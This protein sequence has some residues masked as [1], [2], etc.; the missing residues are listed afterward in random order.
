MD[1]RFTSTEAFFRDASGR[2]S[3]MPD[4]LVGVAPEV[5]RA[6]VCSVLQLGAM[7]PPWSPWVGVERLVPRGLVATPCGLEQDAVADVESAANELVSRIDAVLREIEKPVLLFSGG[8]DSGLLAARLAALGRDDA[9]LFHYSFGASGGETRVAEAMAR[10]F[11]LKLEI[12]GA[13]GMDPLACLEVPGRIYPMPFADESTA[14]MFGLASVVTERFGG[15]G[16]TVIDGTGAD[17]A[18]GMGAKVRQWMKILKIPKGVRKVLGLPYGAGAWL[19]RGGVEYWP[20]LMERS[21]SPSPLAAC[22]A[23]NP[24]AGVL[25]SKEHAG[26]V[27]RALDAWVREEAGD[28]VMRGMVVADLGLTCANIFAQ[29]GAPVLRKAG[30]KISYPFLSDA[31]VELGLAVLGREFSLKAKEILRV[32]L[33]R[34]ALAE[35]VDRRKSGFV[36]PAQSVFLSSRFLEILD[37]AVEGSAPIGDLLVKKN[38]ARACGVLRSGRL[39]AQQ[40]LNCLWAIA[41]TDRWYRTSRKRD[42]RSALEDRR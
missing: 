30:V 17:G 37:A 21:C 24:L 20:R 28:D 12:C 36:D 4:E 39:L 15:E 23:Q 25:Y 42:A 34:Q 8:M 11:G 38:V 3:T 32:A 33:K 16:V 7:V 1:L 6:G 41:F 22:I 31:M 18:F 29:K 2:V 9:V 40:T 35:L 19:R 13:A 5:H 26:E 27:C 10:H 14:P